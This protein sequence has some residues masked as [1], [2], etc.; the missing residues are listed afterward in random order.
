MPTAREPEVIPIVLL[1]LSISGRD[2]PETYVA[3]DKISTLFIICDVIVCRVDHPPVRVA[4]GII[5]GEL[6]LVGAI[7]CAA[8]GAAS[9]VSTGGLVGT[10]VGGQH[11]RGG[12]EKTFVGVV[13]RCLP[14]EVRGLPPE[15]Y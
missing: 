12:R 15:G 3:V 2:V 8:V 5:V 13:K 11:E 14:Y 10:D 6:V 4:F 1:A 7:A 9:H